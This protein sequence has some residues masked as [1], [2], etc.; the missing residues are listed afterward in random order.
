MNILLADDHP[1]FC[2]SL[3]VTLAAIFPECCI[4]RSETWWDVLMHTDE[5]FFDLILLDLMM[6]GASS[7]QWEINLGRVIESRQGA[8]C[9]VSGITDQ[10]HVRQAFKLGVNGYI[11]K[12]FSLE[13]VRS[14]LLRICAGENYC[15]LPVACAVAKQEKANVITRRQREILGLLEK[16]CSNKEIS[17][18]LSLS[19]STVKR[20]IFNLYRAL[21]AK[22][23]ADAIRLG[24]QKGWLS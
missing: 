5:R 3:Q 7:Q 18:A 6:P 24:Y 17:S 1:I 4:V 10:E 22:N 9:V 2:D 19:E 16:G 11:Y 14:I 15:P 21:H 23:R 8:V 13:Q 12:S 20:H